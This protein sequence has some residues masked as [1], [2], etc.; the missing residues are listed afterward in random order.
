MNTRFYE[1][2]PFQID[3]LNHLLLR[4]GEPVPLKPKVFDTLLLLVENRG[5]VLDK[6]EMLGRL[7]PDTV[8]EESNLSQ[9]VYLLRKVL[10]EGM[11]GET[12]IETL[13]KRGYRFVAKVYEIEI[14]TQA[15]AT[16]A[17]SEPPLNDLDNDRVWPAPNHW[18]RQVSRRPIALSL[19]GVLLLF[20]IGSGFYA[21]K[22]RNSESLKSSGPIR[23]VAVLPFR[24]LGPDSQDEIMGLQ[25]ADTLTTRLGTFKQL[26][27]KQTNSVHKFMSPDDDPLAAARELN[28]DAVVD[29]SIQ[30]AGDRVRINLRLVDARDGNAFWS[31]TVEKSTADPFAVQ[32]AVAAAVVQAL[33]RIMSSAEE[34]LPPK[35]HTTNAEAHRL[36]MLGRSHWGTSNEEDWKK[37]LDYF[38]AAVEKDPRYALAYSGLANSY[39]SLIA[40]MKLP[41]PE[42]IPK[43]RQ[44]AMMALQLDDTLA[45]AHVASGRIMTYYD[46]DWAG[47]ER[48]FKRAIELNANSAD[49]YREYAAFLTSVG[50]NEEA[51]AE[52]K[53]AR[54][55]DPTNR[56]TNFQM[57]WTLIGARRYDE[58]IAES[59]QV[60]KTHPD[61]NFWIGMAHVGKG[62]N[63]QAIEDCEKTLS[64]SK[65]HPPAKAALGYAYGATNKHDKAKKLLAEF[66][67]LF[68]QHKTSPYFIAMIY[69]GLRDKDQTFAWL[70]KA[71]YDRSRPL[72]TGLNVNPMWDGLRSD[73]RFV[74]LLQ[75]MRLPH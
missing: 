73:P 72:V 66:E 11:D 13:P 56:A 50:R 30:T 1:F 45:E 21:W 7:W 58:A 60:V 4:N 53:E 59:Q 24:S 17:P 47:A 16:D 34:T 8:V 70:D 75:R 25:L 27:V 22:T 23:S 62:M 33:T 71:Y 18:A 67:E 36:Y 64:S 39:L 20:A 38:N 51:I 43:A 46:W 41:K 54:E 55:L 69:A 49:A 32:D 52:A 5:R 15:S 29:A 12:Y 40:D 48:E 19:I 31:G 2:G 63:E 57:A 68:K 65:P 37:A 74:S 28:V 35:R 14:D 61:A 44:A 10:G 26:R 6:D 42:A 3:K 9:N